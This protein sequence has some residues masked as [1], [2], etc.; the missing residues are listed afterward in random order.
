M[1]RTMVTVA[2]M[3]VFIAPAAA[4]EKPEG[5]RLAELSFDTVDRQSRGFVHYGDMEAA[6]SDIFA[7]IDG[8]DSE[9]LSLS[10][11]LEWDFGFQNVAED[12]NRQHAYR[13]ALK[14]VFS[15]WDRDGDG[16]IT[17]AE[18]R[19]AL[20]TDY[21]RADLNDNFVLEKEEFLS[22]FSVLV[23]IRAA[24]KPH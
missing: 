6:R 17:Q 10:E 24:L 4:Q 15:F 9:E 19:R 21:Q 1:I 20:V 22:G 18:H 12:T 5:R 13:T 2:F 11:F 14:V 23:A 16:S 7:S 3:L 8:D